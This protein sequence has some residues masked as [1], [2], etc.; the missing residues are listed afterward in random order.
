[1]SVLIVGGAG[2]IG[3][4]TAKHVAAAGLTPV[5]FD[6]LSSGHRWALKWGAFEEG[7][8]ADKAALE[9]VMAK[10][11]V[12]AVIHFAGFIQVGESV[13]DPRKYFQNNIVATLTLLDAMVA[14]GV[15][16]VVFSSS[17]AVYGNP[18]R[19]PID[20]EHPMDPLN[21]YG[22]SKAMVERFL[23]WYGDAYGLRW[24]ALRYFNAA[25]ADPDGELGEEH[26]SESHLIPLALQAALGG[27]GL[28][29][30]GTDYP[31]PDGTAIRDYIHVA[32]LADAHVL[33]VRHLA[34]GNESFVA[35]VGTGNG[36]SVRAVIEACERIS[37]RPVVRKEVARRAG[38]SPSLVADSRKLQSLL[39]WRPKYPEL[40]S[41][42]THA[43]KWATRDR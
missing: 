41:M 35:N 3:S 38:D 19:V 32:D 14:R 8:I 29:V 6:N 23:R 15:R 20:E 16:D 42:V 2:F 24:A 37:G 12:T 5:V 28:S 4:Q 17:A 27:P 9:R 18:I 11:A 31:T 7:D 30:F 13:R 39:G 22:D 10:H 36:H 40:E 1:M 26:A 25:G 21:P 34:A 43:F 33:A